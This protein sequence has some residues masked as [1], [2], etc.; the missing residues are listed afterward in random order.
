[1]IEHVSY[2]C[3][4]GGWSEGF[5]QSGISTILALDNWDKAIETHQANHPLSE[6]KVVDLTNYSPKLMHEQYPFINRND[7]NLIF[8][9]SPPC[10]FW[11]RI[12]K[13]KSEKAVE[14]KNLLNC[15]M[16]HVIYWQPGMIALENVPEWRQRERESGLV[17]FKKLLNWL[18]YEYSED[19]M[20][21]KYFGVPQTR[22]RYLMLA[23]ITKM[24]IL[25]QGIEKGINNRIGGFPEINH[26][27]LVEATKQDLRDLGYNPAQIKYITKTMTLH[28]K[29]YSDLA[30]SAGDRIE[31]LKMNNELF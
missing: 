3:G 12:S 16:D 18:G 2:F 30:S 23:K 14:G 13:K 6:H 1:M 28:D 20:Q 25:R 15:F 9:A 10:Q 8:S 26:V 19:I 5:K 29:S 22:T 4:A 11:S 24:N 27:T 17:E 31:G 21:V 7:A